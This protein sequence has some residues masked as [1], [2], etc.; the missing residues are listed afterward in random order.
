MSISIAKTVGGGDGFTEIIQLHFYVLESDWSGFYDQ[1]EVWRSRGLSTGPF[2]EMTADGWKPARIPYYAGDVPAS[3]V[4]GPDLKLVDWDLQLKLDERDD[5]TITFAGSAAS[6]VGVADVAGLH[7]P[8][9]VAGKKLSV[10]VDGVVKPEITIGTPANVGELLTDLN[11]YADGYIFSIMMGWGTSFNL[12]CTRTDITH[13][14]TLALLPGTPDFLVVALIPA[15]TTVGT[16]SLPLSAVAAQ[17]RAGSS[18]RLTSWVDATGQL[19]I[20]TVEPGTSATLRVVGGEA[21]ALL[22]L[23][24]EEPDSFAFGRG[25]RPTL[26]HSH[27]S[28][29][30]ADLR[31]DSSY[32]YRTRYRN[33]V[34]GTTSEFSAVSST[35]SLGVVA[36]D[37]V[38]GRLQLVG[39]DGKPL[40][41]IAVRVFN[42]NASQL[43]GDQL[44]VGTQQDLVTGVD[45]VAQTFLVRGMQITVSIE[46]TDIVRNLT[47][48]IDPAV[49]LFNLLDPDLSIND[50]FTVQT[51]TI[52]VAE[53]RTL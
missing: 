41:N 15:N 47:V 50:A 5:L 18:G 45:G 44:V 34:L 25:C 20:E 24:I 40:S 39:M 1:L 29:V 10:V 42:R 37:V 16:P 9:D 52:V 51:P 23:S 32:F 36:A 38:V 2:E 49:V 27:E 7:Y 48:P 35:Q 14:A 17:I 4:T 3:P 11:S 6:L 8:A 31:G 30:F 12:V 33:R 13:D 26:S 28:Y 21:V 19:A 22:N 53:P 43:V 46:G